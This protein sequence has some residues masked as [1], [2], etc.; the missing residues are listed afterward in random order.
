MNG[1]FYKKLTENDEIDQKLSCSRTK[2]RSMT[3]HFEGY[4]AEIGDQDIPTKFLK[5]KKQIGACITP[6]GNNKCRLCKTSVEDVNHIIA[7]PNVSKVLLLLT[8]SPQRC[9]I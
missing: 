7:Q 6:S 9:C 2:N 3:S 5:H 8:T 1:Y 4:L